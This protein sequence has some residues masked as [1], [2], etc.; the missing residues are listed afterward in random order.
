[1]FA[2]KSAQEIRQL[3]FTRVQWYKYQSLE[4]TLSDGQSCK[5][6]TAHNFTHSHTFNPAK[7]ITKVECRLMDQ[8]YIVQINFYNNTE[9]LVA[10]GQS[11]DYVF[12]NA[13]KREV[14]DIAEDE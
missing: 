7:K 3:R 14:F 6:G 2:S 10:V 12:W 5:A 13:K 11:D 8:K 1:M 4:L 9:R